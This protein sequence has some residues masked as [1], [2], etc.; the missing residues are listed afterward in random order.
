MKDTLISAKLIDW[1]RI[2]L[3]CF[4]SLPSFRLKAR[5]LQDG[6]KEIPLKEERVNSLSSLTIGDFSLEKELELG[7]RYDVSLEGFGLVRLNVDDASLFPDFDERFFYSGDDLGA[8]YQKK[9]TRFALWA[10]LASECFLKWKD[11]EGDLWQILPMSRTPRGVFRA[12]LEGNHA[13]CRYRYLICNSGVLNETTDLYAKASTPNGESSVVADWGK[14]KVDLEKDSLPVLLSPTDAIIYEGHVRDLTIS[15]STDIVRKGTFLGLCEK[16]RKT[17]GGHPAG[18]DYIASLGITHLQLMPIYDF[19]TVDELHPEEKYNW[20][21]DPAQYFVPE[22]SYASVVSD[23]LSRIRD[24]KT[25]VKAYHQSGIRI[26]MDVV[27]NHVYSFED[28]TFQKTVPNYYFRQRKDGSFAST[29]GCGDDLASERAMVRKLIL[30]ACAFWIDEYGVDGFRFDLMGILDAETIRQI[31]SMAKAK[32]PSFLLY[33]EGWNMGG[34][35][36]LP[37]AHMGNHAL[38]PGVGFFNDFFRESAKKAFAGEKGVLNEVKYVFASSSVSF[39]YPPRFLNAKQTINYVECHDNATFFDFLSS[40]RKEWD[41]K[42]KIQS[43]LGACSFVALSFGVPFFHAG[44]EVG[45]TKLGEDNTYNKGDRYNAFPYELVDSR[46]PMVEKFKGILAL[47]KKLKIL[48]AY[49]PTYIDWN[50]DVAEEGP[51]VKVSFLDSSSEES[52]KHATLY[53]NLSENPYNIGVIGERKAFA[54]ALGPILGP[55]GELSVPAF[56]L[57]FVED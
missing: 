57:C 48:H 15:P 1:K 27:F 43:L 29:S 37:L 53:F 56:S 25:L 49:D 23:P 4:S 13:G 42:K 17:A 41:E 31:E 54:S 18:F 10:P 24:L 51:C 52:R 21:Y 7:H 44:Q 11:K 3:T 16:G 45:A 40:R 22:G 19:K 34:E 6:E 14:L 9:A 46:Y 47:R 32:D 35:V 39:F 12:C 20:G 28:S 30:D 2:R 8:S 36:S 38:L 5:L 33:G 50:V 55:K 26:V